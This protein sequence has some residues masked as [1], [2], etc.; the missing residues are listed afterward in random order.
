M[1]DEN[2]WQ[3]VIQF[4]KSSSNNGSA[5]VTRNAS[6]KNLHSSI[7]LTV[8]VRNKFEFRIKTLMNVGLG[9]TAN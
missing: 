9:Y 3:I 7:G 4:T 5:T 2:F 1:L 6:L 8:T